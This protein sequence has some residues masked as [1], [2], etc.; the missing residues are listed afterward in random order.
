MGPDYTRRSPPRAASPRTCETAASAPPLRE[1]CPTLCRSGST[2]Q[3]GRLRSRIVR[4]G[5]MPARSVS[6]PYYK[7][8]FGETSETHLLL[9]APRLE[10]WTAS[11]RLPPEWYGGRSTLPSRGAVFGGRCLRVD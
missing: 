11:A 9:L 6:T 2:E 7:L 3:R 4:A 8:W 5:R 1:T 10:L